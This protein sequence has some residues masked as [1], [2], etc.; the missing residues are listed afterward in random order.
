MTPAETEGI[1]AALGAAAVATRALAGGFSHETRLLTLADGR[2]VVAR[3]G[4]PDPAIE[5][6]VMAAAGAC[7][8]VPY[9]L[10]VLPSPG[11]DARPAMVIDYVAATP[12]SVVLSTE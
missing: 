7:V 3:L 10:L 1:G 4:G 11:E 12:L 9:V 5:A 8:P 2:D 6:A